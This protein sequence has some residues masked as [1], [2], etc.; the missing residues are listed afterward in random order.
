MFAHRSLL[1]DTASRWLICLHDLL[2]DPMIGGFD[3]FASSRDVM[4]G[5]AHNQALS[6]LGYYSVPLG[7]LSVYLRERATEVLD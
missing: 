5:D 4:L 3:D 1:H 6:S 7:G 2:R